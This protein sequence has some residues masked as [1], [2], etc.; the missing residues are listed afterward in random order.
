MLYTSHIMLTMH[1]HAHAQIILLSSLTSLNFIF[2][3]IT[4][5]RLICISWSWVNPPRV[6]YGGGG[7]NCW[8]CITYSMDSC[9]GKQAILIEDSPYFK[10][11]WR[12]WPFVDVATPKKPQPTKKKKNLS[13][14]WSGHI[15]EMI[16]VVQK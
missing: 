13:N 10:G 16:D 12:Q 2:P 9:K 1:T 5:R 7:D 14:T 6:Y 15:Q 4:L 3:V 11:K 8:K